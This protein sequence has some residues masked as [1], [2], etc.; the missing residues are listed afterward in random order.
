M[1]DRF[2]R[3]ARDG[4]LDLLKEATRKDCNTP[5]EDGL[6]PT[7][8]AAYEGN[9]EALRLLV[10]RGGDPDR[11]DHYGNTALHCAA[12]KGHMNC[13]SFLV[14]F[15]ANLWAQDND[16]H[17]AKELAAMNNRE[18]ILRYLDTVFA[19]QE[20]SS[21]KLVEKLKA[22]SQKD[23]E[24]RRKELEKLQKKADKRRSFEEKVLQ[25]ERQKIEKSEEKDDSGRRRQSI[26]ATLS[27][28]S[29]AFI[30]GPRK[31][32]RLLYSN[33]PIS[34]KF[35]EL[36]TSNTNN[37]AKKTLGGI[38][39]RI[40]KKKVQDENSNN[41]GEFKVGEMT[42]GKRSVRS[43]TGLQRDSEI[44][45]VPNGS[46]SSTSS[47]GK[48]GKLSEVF[49]T[50][51]AANSDGRLFRARSEPDFAMIGSEDHVTTK[52]SLF[53]RPGFGSVAF[54]S[55]IT[56]T[57][58]SLTT[59]GSSDSAKISGSGE[60]SKKG[61]DSIGS[62]GSLANREMSPWDEEDLPSE[63]EEEASPI[64]LFLAANGL[65]DYI[66][67]FAR[68]HIDLDALMLLTDQDLI[69]LKLPLGPRRKLLKAIIE[70]ETALN[71]PGEVA[72]SK[73]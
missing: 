24:K 61:G 48:R 22:K 70:R 55:S 68:E 42:D 16:F 36:T 27:R 54:R 6:T 32:S 65:S 38:K 51:K 64:F 66:P 14:N 29:L 25:R 13:V 1:T 72:D 40:V 3:A 59:T 37:N 20:T 43:I 50:N 62:A 69:N 49:D 4:Y 58:T 53:D 2:H 18:E 30:S 15:G 71:N 5:D 12:A 63:D 23:V 67:I 10:G 26:L 34:P 9:L 52:G 7:A 47:V 11:C 44:L 33:T 31:D 8:W 28:S 41:T 35:S 73:L 45:F 60:V 19:K 56:A 39:K 46:L 17:S 21:P 57:L